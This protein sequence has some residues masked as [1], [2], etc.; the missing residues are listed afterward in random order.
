MPEPSTHKIPPED[1]KNDYL[2][3]VYPE[4]YRPPEY[5][6]YL[7]RAA[8][9]IKTVRLVVYA[10]MTCFVLLAA[11]GFFLIYSLT[12]DTH[13]MVEHVGRISEQMQ[14]MTRI[15]SNMHETM[16]D[17]RTSFATLPPAMQNMDQNMTTMTQTVGNMANTVVLL[18]HSARNLDQSFGPITGLM[19]NLPFGMG[20][21][22][23]GPPPAAPLQ[24]PPR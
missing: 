8:G 22:Y 13:R 6:A 2:A 7:E 3:Q 24:P 11:Y 5:L 15:M 14:S 19:N 20:S 4:T 10:G 12:L 16:L 9:A 1:L 18:Q 23:H 21:R 17:M